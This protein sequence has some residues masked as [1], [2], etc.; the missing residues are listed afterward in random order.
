LL[1]EKRVIHEKK[2]EKAKPLGIWK[3]RGDILLGNGGVKG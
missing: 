2:K 1:D 3:K